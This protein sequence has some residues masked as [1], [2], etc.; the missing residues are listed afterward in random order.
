[1]NIFADVVVGVLSSLV[2]S[3]VWLY[4]IR[5][6]RPKLAISTQVAKGKAPDGKTIYRIKVVNRSRR[7]AMQLQAK[8]SIAVGRS[9]P[10][11]FL[12]QRVDLSLVTAQLMALPP[13]DLNDS[14]AQYAYR[15]VTYDDLDMIW[16]PDK[17]EFLVFRLFAT[18]S[19]SGLG[20]FFEQRYLNKNTSIIGA[21]FASGP[22]LVVTPTL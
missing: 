10:T 8:L 2:A 3:F 15:F 1:M 11:G 18:D 21:N 22:S 9:R 4:A 17:D 12:G 19:I 7:A 6:Y 16:D 20:S 13:L 5:S 14:E